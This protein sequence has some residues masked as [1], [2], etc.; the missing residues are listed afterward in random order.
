MPPKISKRPAPCSEEPPELTEEALR[1]HDLKSKL[2]LWKH[3]KADDETLKKSL[4]PPETQACWMK[5]E[6]HR[7]KLQKAVE[8]WEGLRQLG[9]GQNKD[10]KKR[11]FLLAF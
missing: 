2:E 3:G 8:E 1:K 4:T 7:G 11:L 10:Q 6:F 9:R 5:F